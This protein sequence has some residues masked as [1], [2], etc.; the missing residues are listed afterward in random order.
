MRL[1][2]YLIENQYFTSREQAKFNIVKGNVLVNG[3]V[4]LKPSLPIVETDVVSVNQDNA[5]RYVSRGG[6]KL[7]K[8]LSVFGINC[9]GLDVIDIGASTGGFT[10]CAL[11]QGAAHVCAVDVGTNQLAELL[12]NDPR[13]TSMEGVS[14]KDLDKDKLSPSKFHL[15]VTDLSFISLT[16]VMTHFID[17]LLPQGVVVA[18]IKPQF[19]VGLENIGKGGIVKHAD[20]HQMA[21]EKVAAAA[22]ECGLHLRGLTW[23]PILSTSKN[24]E[25]LAHFNQTSPATINVT[26]VVKNAFADRSRVQKL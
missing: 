14:I 24:I 5:M 23:A 13:V 16:K 8:A 26:H 25:Y 4:V 19:E 7:E 15:L 21:I 10:D 22:Q 17:L 11:Q 1:D 20:A 3:K 9:N 2:V 12:R 6:L 18:L